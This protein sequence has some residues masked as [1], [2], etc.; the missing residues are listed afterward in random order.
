MLIGPA[1]ALAL[2]VLVAFLTIAGAVLRSPVV[3]PGSTLP[4]VAP[5]VSRASFV[6]IVVSRI[7]VFVFAISSRDDRTSFSQFR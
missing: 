3:V 5:F 6:G 1:A 4:V 2:L 7:V